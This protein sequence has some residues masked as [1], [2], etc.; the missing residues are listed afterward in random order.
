ML[1]F[2]CDYNLGACPEILEKL[3]E[4]NFIPR[5]GYGE[6][7]FSVQ[8]KEKIRK[9]CACEDA[10]I[11]FLA[12][13]TQTNQVVID[14][15]LKPYE[16][17]VAA[18]TGHV[19]AHEAGAIEFTG[20]KVLTIPQHD[21]KIDAGE[22][23]SFVE[24]FYADGN[25]EH[26]VFPGMVYISHPTEYGTLYSKAE[27]EA[28]KDVCTQFDMC[29]YLDGARL[30]YGL[31]SAESD[32]DI[33]DI[34]RL[35]DVFYIGGTKVGALFGEAL[36]FTKNNTPAHF[37]NLIKKHGALIAKGSITALQFDALFTDGLYW[38]LGENAIRTA[39]K[40]KKVLR[41]KGYE[42]Y[43][44]SPTNQQFVIV[45][46]EKLEKLK[47]QVN[48]GFWEKYDEHRTVIRFASSWATKDEDIDALAEIL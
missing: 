4:T 43:L 47:E 30:A 33:K 34:A 14:T 15:M 25:A 42:F 3:C 11:Y 35:C 21:G 19:S 48:Y 46:N 44:N 9:E 20:H 38:R 28:I 27:L 37:V 16:G 29:L 22:L 17:V 32:M 13:G 45:E 5:P 41:E 26:M 1:S 6:D 36:V 2:E 18:Q 40:L 39:Q 24:T 12:G 8:A 7:E 31:M 10:D 23:K